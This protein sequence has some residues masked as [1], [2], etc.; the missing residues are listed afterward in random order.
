LRIEV[1]DSGVGI[2]EDQRQ[3]IFNEFY[4]VAD[5]RADQGGLGLG[6][7]IVDRLCRLLAHPLDVAS[8]PG[9]GS[10][11]AITVP[12]APAGVDRPEAADPFDA[13]MRPFAG[14]FVL[15]IDDD[16]LVLEGMGGLLRSWGCRVSG[17]TSAGASL[18]EALALHE[19]PDLVICDYHLGQAD[20][21]I[22]VIERLREAFDAP[23]PALLITGDISPERR[24][25]AEAGGYAILQKPVAPSALRAMLQAL[26]RSD[27]A[28]S[29]RSGAREPVNG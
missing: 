18:A 6:L 27:A 20:N 15:V 16:R 23:V 26:S 22:A 10:R 21:G 17:W 2:P 14:K 25:E 28:A 4:K 1:W 12:Q 13:A 11:F 3:S 5:G 7:A 19:Q 24:L 9:K 8:T 29:A